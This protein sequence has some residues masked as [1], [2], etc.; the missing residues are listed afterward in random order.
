VELADTAVDDRLVVDRTGWPP[1]GRSV[2][3]LL[4][5]FYTAVMVPYNV[6]FRNKTLDSPAIL[7][8]DAVVDVVFSTNSLTD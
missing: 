4:L 2:L 5:T 8:V 6:A 7:I 3:I 1:R